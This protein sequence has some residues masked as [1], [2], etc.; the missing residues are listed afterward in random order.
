[1]PAE[2]RLHHEPS[3]L[4]DR[5]ALGLTRLLRLVSRRTAHRLIGFD[6]C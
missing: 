1:M 2:P 3:D 4:A 5:F 6:K